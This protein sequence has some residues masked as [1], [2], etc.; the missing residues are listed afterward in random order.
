M[1][2]I[3]KTLNGK[4]YCECMIQDGTERWHKDSLEVAIK[5]M[6]DT[7]F[8]MNGAKIKKSQIGFFEQ[9]KVTET[10]I[11]RVKSL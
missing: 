2:S 7:A 10:K 6:K 8:V 1:Y 3:T 11:V 5:S 9:K 4:Y